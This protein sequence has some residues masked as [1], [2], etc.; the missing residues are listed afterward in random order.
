MRASQLP[1]API[2]TAPG[3]ALVLDRYRLVRRLGAGAFGVVWLGHDERL[4][5]QVAVKVVPR[6][7]VLQARLEREARAAA[8]LSHPAI[9]TLFEAAVDDECAYLVS[10]L[11]RGHTLHELLAAG[12]LSDRDVVAIAIALCDA[13][14]H[15][16]AQGVIHRDVKPSNVLVPE[17]PS[18]PSHP[19]KLTDF[20]VARVVGGD[21]LTRTGDVVG[22]A[23]YMAPEQAEG[24]EAGP[25]GRPV[26]ARA[27]D[28]RGARPAPTRP[29]DH[30]RGPRP[31][32]RRLPA[33]AAPPPPRSSAG[34]RPRNRPGAAPAPPRARDRGG[35]TRRARQ[36]HACPRRHAGNDRDRPSGGQ[37]AIAGVR[38]GAGFRHRGRDRPR[39][40]RR[41]RRQPRRPPARSWPLAGPSGDRCCRRPVAAWVTIP[42][43]RRESRSR[44]DRRVA[45]RSGRP[46]RSPG[47]AGWAR[48][49]RS[50]VRLPPGSRRA[51][52]CSCCRLA[53]ARPRRRVGS[54]GCAGPSG[55]RSLWLWVLAAGILS[56][57]DADRRPRRPGHRL[58]GRRSRRRCRSPLTTY[59]ADR[60]LRR[61][62]RR[63]RVGGGGGTVA[64]VA[65]RAA[66]SLLRAHRRCAGAGP[67]SRWPPPRARS[68]RPERGNAVSVHA[69][70]PLALLA[71]RR[72]WRRRC[73]GS[74]AC[75]RP[76]AGPRPRPRRGRRT[77]VA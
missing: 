6:E 13:L 28:L 50:P 61:A 7:R 10:E 15:A 1:T 5:R 44:A 73:G 21:T 37:R 29:E 3:P 16:H 25:G 53:A 57:S 24:L 30:R 38:P 60:A 63:G 42:R 54:G 48:R 32:A 52:A 18:S 64:P 72:H 26:R 59:R 35:A 4:D 66:G 12:R 31:P 58:P 49:A 23:A 71:T 9:V 70:L 75:A 27:R 67:P 33:A 69:A 14:E 40:D 47:S 17:A 74:S 76:R 11:V 34:A 45:G 36:Q 55:A 51:P 8:R 39:G 43:A 68:G 2:A 20:G 77:S 56:A 65:H 46:R 19:V 41:R 22:T 62:R